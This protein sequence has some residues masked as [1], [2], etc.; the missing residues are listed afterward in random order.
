MVQNEK[1]TSK[2]LIITIN[3]EFFP[4]WMA[5]GIRGHNG[6]IVMA[7]WGTED[8]IVYTRFPAMEEKSVLKK[9]AIREST[10]ER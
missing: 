7:I 4:Q 2:Q 1:K 6:E 10:R 3:Y 9:T 8:A 5:D